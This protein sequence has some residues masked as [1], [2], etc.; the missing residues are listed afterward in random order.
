MNLF[1]RRRH[2]SGCTKAI[3]EELNVGDLIALDVRQQRKR[4]RNVFA[5]RAAAIGEGPEHR[6]GLSLNKN[7]AHLKC[8]GFPDP[9][10]VWITWAGELLMSG[11]LFFVSSSM[12]SPSGE[13]R[14]G[15]FVI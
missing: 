15:R 1:G 14:V 4:R 11:L 13:N 12:N 9:T 8:S 2:R 3:L 5:R 7:F 6:D 10:D